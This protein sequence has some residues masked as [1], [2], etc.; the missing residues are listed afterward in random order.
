MRRGH[1]EKDEETSFVPAYNRKRT[2]LDIDGTLLLVD[3][4]RDPFPANGAPALSR[5][6]NR[7]PQFKLK[8][9]AQHS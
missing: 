3:R 6:L 4:E 8:L 5:F 2:D 7:A 1:V 9:F